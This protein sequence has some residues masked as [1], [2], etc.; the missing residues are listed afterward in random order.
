MQEPAKTPAQHPLLVVLDI[1]VRRDSRPSG[2]E[3]ALAIGV[4][5]PDGVVWWEAAFGP[6]PVARF[7]EVPEKASTWLLLGQRDADEILR[8]GV[9]ETE[10]QVLKLAG[11]PELVRRF[12]QRY[13]RRRGR[14]ALRSPAAREDVL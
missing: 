8:G 14:V 2:F 10:S 11:D 9:L 6:K 7:V 5:M 13:M 3:G 4:R 1:V 12:S